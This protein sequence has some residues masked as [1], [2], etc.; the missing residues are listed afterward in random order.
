[1]TIKIQ[2]GETNTIEDKKRMHLKFK[3]LLEKRKKQQQNSVKRFRVLKL[4]L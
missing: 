4:K 3:F 2:H 1:M